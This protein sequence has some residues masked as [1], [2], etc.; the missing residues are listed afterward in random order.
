MSIETIRMSKRTVTRL[1]VGGF[2][3]F[4]AGLV[5]AFAGRRRPRQHEAD[6]GSA[7]RESWSGS[8]STNGPALY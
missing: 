4:C 3:A 1:F 5:L 6:R 2:V 7:H 8:V